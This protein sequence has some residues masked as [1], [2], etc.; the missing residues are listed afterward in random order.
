VGI[1]AIYQVRYMCSVGGPRRNSVYQN[2]KVSDRDIGATEIPSVCPLQARAH[3]RRGFNTN[4]FLDRNK[5]NQI[6]KK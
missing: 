4:R 2:D 6:R 1:V 3:S 5:D